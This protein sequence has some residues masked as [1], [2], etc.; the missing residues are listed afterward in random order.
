MTKAISKED[1]FNYLTVA[2][3]LLLL[4]N[5]ILEQFLEGA[6]QHY[7]TASLIVVLAVGVWSL[8]AER[9]SFNIGIGLVLATLVI[10]ALN[11]V[12]DRTG[13]SELHLVFLLVYLLLTTWQAAKQ[14]LFSG[15]IDANKIVGS[16][17]I[18]LLLGLIW[19][20]TYL[21]ILAIDPTS[22]NGVAESEWYENFSSLV[23]Y[24]FVTLTT[25]GYGEITP[26]LPI[27]RFF[28]YAEAITGQFYMAIL[29]ASLIGAR[30]SSRSGAK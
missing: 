26:N 12:L 3:I 4:V 14:V 6:G 29:V 18:Y 8:R 24:S 30:L 7:V 25:V 1:N 11:L 22:F 27:A 20:F 15:K 2:L 21:L 9:R 10:S 5:A 16:I 28:A 13:L 23:Y 17:C 19:A